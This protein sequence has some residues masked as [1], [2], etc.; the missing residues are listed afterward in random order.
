MYRN[1]RSTARR[2]WIGRWVLAGL[3]IGVSACRSTDPLSNAYA[4]WALEVGD[5]CS[6]VDAAGQCVVYD[7][8]LVELI[9]VPE[10]FHG[11]VVRV[12]GYVTL[13]FESNGVCLSDDT[14]SGRDCVFLDVEGVEDP[15][16]RKDWALVQGTFD[17][18]LRGHLG[19]CSGTIHSI[20]RLERWRR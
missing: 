5:R 17:G 12:I 20:S 2:G 14:R 6:Q 15:G 13:G 9:A 18:E 7:V 3:L 11:K 4:G 16:F 19:C 10:K 8:S 1:L